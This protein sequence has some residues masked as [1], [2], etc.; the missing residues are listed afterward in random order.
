M[1]KKVLPKA[2]PNIHGKVWPPLPLHM[3]TPPPS[4]KQPL[5]T[6]CS[7]ESVVKFYWEHW[8]GSYTLCSLF[9]VTEGF[10]CGQMLEIFFSFFFFFAFFS[11]E[12][13]EAELW[14]ERLKKKQNLRQSDIHPNPKK[15]QPEYPHPRKPQTK[16]MPRK[17]RT[18]GLWKGS[19]K[20]SVKN[21]VY[22]ILKKYRRLIIRSARTQ[23]QLTVLKAKWK[24]YQKTNGK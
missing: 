8:T 19:S 12:T 24:V 10:W 5:V 21:Q 15:P 18:T 4:F 16:L 22:F 17:R 20:V 23:I 11:P 7:V 13:S 2:K 14:P 1:Q 6:T 9:N 3:Q